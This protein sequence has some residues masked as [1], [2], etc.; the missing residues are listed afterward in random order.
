MK[1]ITIRDFPK[2]EIS[3][4]NV[5]GDIVVIEKFRTVNKIP[6]EIMRVNIIV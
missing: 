2:K 4:E 1:K 6:S 5:S 3:T